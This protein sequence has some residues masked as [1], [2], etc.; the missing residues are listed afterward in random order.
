[1]LDEDFCRICQ[2]D[3]SDYDRARCL[4]FPRVN[5]G[6]GTMLKREY[7]NLDAIE[8][9]RGGMKTDVIGLIE[10]ITEI[11]PPESLGE[12]L[13][14]HVIEHFYPKIAEKILKDCFSLMLAGAKIIVECP[15]VEGIIELWQMKHHIMDTQEKV[16][17]NLYGSN[18]TGWKEFGW[19]RWGYTKETMAKLVEDCG[20]GV[21]YKG[22][23]VLH[24]MGKRDLRVEGVKK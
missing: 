18:E 16:I 10:D 14:V 1:M 5:L 11:F 4:S 9:T 6:S 12:I 17:R 15:D 22:V 7:I 21:T 13:I 3:C 19:H 20:F 23:G 8:I 24:G 2:R